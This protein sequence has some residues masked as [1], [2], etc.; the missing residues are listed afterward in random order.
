MHEAALAAPLL[1]LVLE[2]HAGL[3]DPQLRV[4]RVLVRAGI[5]LGIEPAQLEGI[6]ELM[7]ESTP[8]EG[9]ALIVEYE[10]LRARCRA[11]GKSVAVTSRRIVC[12]E[13]ACS[14]LE[15]RGGRELYIASITVGPAGDHDAPPSPAL[16][17]QQE[18]KPL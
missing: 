14:D 6:F 10:P 8:A 9:A 13:C 5:L 7:A 17:L 3:A 18:A 15:P 12:P 16:P 2:E 4:K 11:C 1:R